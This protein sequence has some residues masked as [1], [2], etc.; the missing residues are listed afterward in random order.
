MEFDRPRSDLSEG[1]GS[2]LLLESGAIGAADRLCGELL[3]GSDAIGLI[4]VTL[5]QP[6]ETRLSVRADALDG[7][8]DETVVVTLDGVADISPDAVPDDVDVRTVADPGNLTRLGV[9]L[10]EALAAV[11][12]TRPVLCFH[13]LSVLLQYAGPDRVYRF[14]SVLKTHLDAAGATAHFHLDPSTHDDRTV[15]AFRTLFDDVVTVDA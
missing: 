11:E 10:T 2:I 14:L 9:A 13:S 6:P 3:G 1:P 5:V 15:E 4:V 8:P 7:L 12:G